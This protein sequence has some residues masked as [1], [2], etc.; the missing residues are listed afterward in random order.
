MSGGEK[1]DLVACDLDG[2]LFTQEEVLTSFHYELRDYIK[3]KQIP[4][5]FVSGRSWPG[6]RQPVEF[7]NLGLPVVG[8]NGGAIYRDQAILW[9]KSYPASSVRDAIIEADK[10]QMAVIFTVGMEE[11]AYR[12][13]PFIQR[14]IEAYKRYGNEWRPGLKEWQD[15]KMDKLL[16]ID[17]NQPGKIDRVLAKLTAQDREKLQVVRYNDYSVDITAKGTDKARGLHK[18]MDL[19]QVKRVVAFGDDL[20]DIGFLQEADWGVAMVNAKAE[21]QAV[22]DHVTDQEGA[23]GI[24]A[25][26]QELVS[27]DMI[28][29]GE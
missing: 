19:L 21:L 2:T 14:R 24:L 5:T 17:P 16:I 10:L 9:S 7:F 23:A 15:L 3:Q 8:N 29:L 12:H 22:A 25:E 1:F 20:N 11:Y 6:L 13:I 26:L 27:R 4:F 28:E 18:L